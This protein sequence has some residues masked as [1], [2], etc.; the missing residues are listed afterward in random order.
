MFGMWA[1]MYL[2]VVRDGGEALLLRI[3]DGNACRLEAA[4]GHADG[5][6]ADPALHMH[7]NLRFSWHES[8]HEGTCCIQRLKA[9]FVSGRVSLRS[10]ELPSL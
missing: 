2:H 5:G 7:S 4:L 3:I 9:Q 6:V 1:V 10:A 8:H